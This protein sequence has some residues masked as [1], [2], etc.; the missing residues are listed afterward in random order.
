MPALQRAE[1][2]RQ[3]RRPGALL[4]LRGPGAC[5]GPGPSAW[6]RP[7]QAMRLCVV[8][9]S[10]PRDRAGSRRRLTPSGLAVRHRVAAHRNRGPRDARPRLHSQREPLP[11]HPYWAVQNVE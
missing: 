7:G 6:S 10:A 3:G 8:R 11:S 2:V 9:R 1:P 4:V 5:R